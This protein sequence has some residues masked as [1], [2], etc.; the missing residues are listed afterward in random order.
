MS[1]GDALVTVWIVVL[2]VFWLVCELKGWG[3]T[4]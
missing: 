4:H 3:I 2:V 1:G